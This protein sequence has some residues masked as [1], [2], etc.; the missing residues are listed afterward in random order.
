MKTWRYYDIT[1]TDERETERA[2]IYAFSDI[3]QVYESLASSL[4][5]IQTGTTEIE[6]FMLD[7]TGTI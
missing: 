4:T 3:K 2:C 7:A 1:Q 5:N 6:D